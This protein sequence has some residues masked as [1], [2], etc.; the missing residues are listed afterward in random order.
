MPFFVGAAPHTKGSAKITTPTTCAK[1]IHYRC[2]KRVA[3]D[4]IG[5]HL[6]IS[7]YDKRVAFETSKLASVSGLDLCWN[8]HKG[9]LFYV[10]FKLLLTTKDEFAVLG[11]IGALKFER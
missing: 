3:V 4:L 11:I 2:E 6:F 9:T 5:I 7:N 8:A 10:V 1:V